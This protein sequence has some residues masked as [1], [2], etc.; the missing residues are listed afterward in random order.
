ME[1]P[2]LKPISFPRPEYFLEIFEK[3]ILAEL[4]KVI[5]EEATVLVFNKSVCHQASSNNVLYDIA[6]VLL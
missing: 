6:R 3:Y 2:S 5:T 4:V 1:S